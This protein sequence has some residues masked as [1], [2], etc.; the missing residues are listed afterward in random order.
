[1][2]LQKLTQQ[3]VKQYY[4]ESVRLRPTD[5]DVMT[6]YEEKMKQG[7]SFPHVTFGEYPPEG[8]KDNGKCIVDGLHR[9]GAF[10]KLGNRVKLDVEILKYKTKADAMC[11]M[12]KRNQAH[13]LRVSAEDRDGRI[14][15][16]NQL[17]WEGKQIAEAISLSGASVSRI[18]QGKQSSGKSG[19]K[20]GQ[21]KGRAGIKALAPKP[22][23]SHLKKIRKTLVSVTAKREISDFVHAVGEE[24][25]ITTNQELIDLV[26]EVKE[27]INR[28]FPELKNYSKA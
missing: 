24:K 7:V 17:G 10:Q 2:S 3:L 5:P 12:Y 22:F 15:M 6:D 1:M 16:L 27:Q 4:N 11:D 20:K 19:P 21:A 23:F 8:E 28:F 13:G 26:E 14:R 25:E 9:V 18:L